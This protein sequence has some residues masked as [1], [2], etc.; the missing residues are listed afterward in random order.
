[1]Y[2]INPSVQLTYTAAANI[3]HLSVVSILDKD[4]DSPAEIGMQRM[5]NKTRIPHIARYFL[6]NGASHPITPLI[7]WVRLT[8]DVDKA[9][10]KILWEEGDLAAIC[11]AWGKHVLTI[12]D[13]QHRQAGLWQAFTEARDGG[14]EFNPNVPMQ[15]LF[16]L[17]YEQAAQIFLDINGNGKNVPGATQ[18]IIAG[19]IT[20]RNDHDHAQWC[21]QVAFHLDTDDHSAWKGEFDLEGKGT[22]KSE[23]WMQARLTMAAVPRGI[24]ALI[25]ENTTGR[26][27]RGHNVDPQAIVDHYWQA[28]KMMTGEAWDYYPRTAGEKTY[29]TKTRLRDV[30][31]FGALCSLGSVIINNA[32]SNGYTDTAGVMQEMSNLMLPLKDVDWRLEDS[33]PWIVGVGAGWAGASILFHRL[34]DYVMFDITP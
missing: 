15:L 30:A 26:Y 8:E 4:P 10:F 13:G 23:S 9:A 32:M 24:Q 31:G 28:V 1:M 22:P 6:K 27:L 2:Q 7:V 19:K 25:P 21:R 20:S 34:R 3:N 14:G 11:K 16:D 5:L 12:L 17:T 33:N 18:Q 29:H